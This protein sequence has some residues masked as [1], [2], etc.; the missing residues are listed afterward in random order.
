MSTTGFVEVMLTGG[1]GA[2]SAV[3]GLMANCTVFA[4]AFAAGYVLA[5]P[6][7][8]A[9]FGGPRIIARPLSMLANIVRALPVLLIAFWCNLLWPL[10]RG[11]PSGPLMAALV[12]L[13]VYAAVSLSDMLLTGARAVPPAELEAARGVGM[14]SLHLMASLV[15]P[16]M[17]RRSIGSVTSF[18]TSLFKDTS[19]LYIVGVSDVLHLAMIATEREPSRL[20]FW[21]AMVAACFVVVCQL[22]SL[23]GRVLRRRFDLFQ[24]ATAQAV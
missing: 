24:P 12:A 17:L 5:I 7:A 9:R 2:P 10:I 14:G 8:L 21:Y 22:I 16:Q 20:L 13:T 15:L 6:L 11:Q 18:A 23:V 19:I 3:G 4:V 1:D